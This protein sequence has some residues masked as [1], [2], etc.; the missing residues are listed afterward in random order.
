MKKTQLILNIVFGVALIALFA[1]HLL[2]AGNLSDNTLTTHKKTDTS[3]LGGEIVYVNIDTV[4]NNYDLFHELKSKMETRFKTAQ[5]EIS[6]KEENYY[7]EVEDFQYKVQ[8]GLV[9]RSDAQKLQQQLMQEEQKLLQLRDN[10]NMEL[11]E[12]ES[13]VQRQLINEIMLFLDEYNKSKG[14]TYILA[15]RFGSNILYSSEHLDITWDVIE[16]LNEKYKKNRNK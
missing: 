15:N 13:V 16:G 12:E 6:S 8:R 9:T 7:K 1:L 3:G 4:L 11:A 2:P 5:S 10:L 14:Y